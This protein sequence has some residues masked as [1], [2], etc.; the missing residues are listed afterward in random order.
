MVVNADPSNFLEMKK[1]SEIAAIRDS[2]E[3]FIDSE[4]PLDFA[5]SLQNSPFPL[6]TDRQ[7][8][9][10]NSIHKSSAKAAILYGVATWEILARQIKV[11]EESEGR[12]P[13]SFELTVAEQL[14]GITGGV[15][16]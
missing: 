2:G 5:I 9:D 3:F 15:Y 16:E 12:T 10:C 8:V 1:L 7:L 13:P 14:T 11:F 4:V 6:L